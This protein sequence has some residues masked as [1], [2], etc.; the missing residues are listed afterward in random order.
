MSDFHVLLNFRF[1]SLFLLY[2]YLCRSGINI[3][4]L[5]VMEPKMNY[6]AVKWVRYVTFSSGGGNS[7]GIVKDDR[8]GGG[9]QFRI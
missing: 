7:K 6:Q 1:F 4:F 2:I 3:R 5:K 8:S 9:F